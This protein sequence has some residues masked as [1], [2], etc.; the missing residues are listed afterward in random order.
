MKNVSYLISDAAKKVDVEAHVLRYWE[1][2][3][4]LPIHRNELGHRYYTP[5]D[6]ERFQEIKKLKEQG[7]QLKAIRLVL[8]EGKMKEFMER[9]ESNKVMAIEIVEKK[10]DE[11]EKIEEVVNREVKEE[12][13]AIAYV[14]NAVDVIGNDENFNLS[15]NSTTQDDK[16][17]RLQCLLQKMMRDALQ[18]NNE[19][20]THE[21][22]ENVVK[23]I[24][25]QFRIMEEREE[26]KYNERI[27]R[28][29]NH[30]KKIDELL[31]K[32]RKNFLN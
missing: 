2:E 13:P 17:H 28:E 29:E 25:Y 4:E 19:T 7:L 11:K 31:R 18:E 9:E 16:V 24:D 5:D 3:L 12:E 22:K 32:K 27:K 15:N 14:N 26:E 23:E 20:L 6:V 1:G 8:A 10:E 30:Y 21:I